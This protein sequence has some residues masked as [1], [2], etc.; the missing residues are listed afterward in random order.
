MVVWHAWHKITL[1]DGDVNGPLHKI[2]DVG[3]IDVDE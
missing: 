2:G 3:V 1:G